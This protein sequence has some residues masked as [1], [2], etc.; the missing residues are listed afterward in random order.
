VA[1]TKT[2]VSGFAAGPRSQKGKIKTMDLRKQGGTGG[3]EGVEV[4]MDISADKNVCQI[5]DSSP[6]SFAAFASVAVKTGF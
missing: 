6:V 1:A 5:G 4:Y 3:T 2:D